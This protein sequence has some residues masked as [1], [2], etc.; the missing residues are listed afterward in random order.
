MTWC[1]FN[2]CLF[3]ICNNLDI[4]C[5]SLHCTGLKNTFRDATA[6]NVDVY[7]PLGYCAPLVT[8]ELGEI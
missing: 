5:C 4:F 8:C 7:A 3:F 6:F 2:L 1:P